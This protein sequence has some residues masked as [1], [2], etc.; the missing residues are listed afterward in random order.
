MFNFGSVFKNKKMANNINDQVPNEENIEDC[1]SDRS[2]ALPYI[3]H[4][5]AI[6]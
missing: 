5:G 3:C 2:N 4:T 6:H 1:I